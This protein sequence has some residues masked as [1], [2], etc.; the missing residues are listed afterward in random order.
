M[1]PYKWATFSS[2]CQRK[3]EGWRDLDFLILKIEKGLH[4]LNNSDSLR[5]WK[6]HR[7]KSL[8]EDSRRESALLIFKFRQ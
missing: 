7:D 5:S 8:S 4:E 6:N 3:N 1:S 2:H